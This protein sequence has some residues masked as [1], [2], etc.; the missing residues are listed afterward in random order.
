MSEWMPH[1]AP[2]P[3]PSVPLASA[4]AVVFRKSAFGYELLWIKR[5]SQ[6]RFAPQFYV[7]PGGKRA[8]EDLT[9]AHTALRELFE[10]TAI[11]IG[12]EGERRA[13]SFDTSCCT[14]IGTWTTP[15]FAPLR[16]ETEF[17]VVEAPPNQEPVANADELEEAVFVSPAEALGLWRAGRAL[18]HPPALHIFRC[19][20]QGLELS[21]TVK[22]LK[23]PDFVAHGIALDIEFQHGIRVFPLRTLTLPP[24]THTNCYLLGNQEL[25]IVDVGTDSSAELDRLCQHLE[26]LKPLGFQAVALLATHHHS[27]HISGM[28]AMQRRLSLPLW[29]HADTA[30]R[31]GVPVSRVLRD[32]ETIELRGAPTMQLRVLHTPG[33]ARG[34]VC[35]LDEHS[36][37]CVV[38]DMLAGVGTIVIDPPEGNMALYEQQLERL[39]NVPIG[40]AY[41]AHGPALADGVG[42]IRRLLSHRQAREI[43]VRAAL[44]TLGP[45]AS[46]SDIVTE[47]YRDTPQAAWPLAER[48]TVA[49]LR[50]LAEIG[51]VKRRSDWE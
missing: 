40:V 18:L 1:L 44:D 3:E 50:K 19:F 36:K 51:V 33:H 11:H 12:S 45:D 5:A 35:L 8:Q 39:A 13:M 31:L 29:A 26:A 2:A 9:L 4:C 42:A 21:D 48:N 22:Q 28:A 17:F 47:T 14:S 46:L 37:A 15:D 32:G 10:E 24:A 38:G 49:I 34:H 25:L 27:D 16:F 43:R 6:L 41:P 7:F 23:S 20:A 30:S